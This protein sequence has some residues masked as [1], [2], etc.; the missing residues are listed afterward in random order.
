MD[1]SKIKFIAS[2][3]KSFYLYKSPRT[4]ILKCNAD[5]F[6]NRQCL[7]KN[8]IPKYANIKV[9]V[10]SKATHITQKKISSVRIKDE[11]K[12]LYKKKDQLKKKLYQVHLE[13]AQEWDTVWHVI[14][15]HIDDHI[16]KDMNKK[17]TL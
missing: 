15:E 14:R 9:P 4:K 1:S 8:I 17:Y 13:L 5:I 3:A 12:F 10:T 11:I 7:T 6:F 16:N 2:Q